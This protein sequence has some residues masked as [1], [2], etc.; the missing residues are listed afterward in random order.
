MA[1]TRV[2]T[3]TIDVRTVTGTSHSFSHTVPTGCDLLI[4]CAGAQASASVT[5]TPSWDGNNLTL[6]NQ[7]TSSAGNADANNWCYGLL[8][9]S[10]ATGTLSLA[11]LANNEAAWVACVNFAGTDTASIAAA[12]NF[13]TE[14]V[15]DAETSTS[16]HASGGSS[17]NA[18]LFVGNFVG[19]DGSPATNNASFT[20]IYD[21]DTGGGAGNNND[22]SCYIAELLS[23][24]PSAIVVTWGAT[25][26]NAS[27]LIELVNGINTVPMLPKMLNEGQVNG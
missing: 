6:I 24:L 27:Q 25:D 19:A 22:F 5:G 26:E 1:V 4:V 15:N 17:G 11:F 2:G 3:E 23:G 20:E 18:L 7:T 9:P 8:S 10:N 13:V 12:T 14:D 16:V 21:T